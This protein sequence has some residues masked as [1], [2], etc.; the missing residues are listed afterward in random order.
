MHVCVDM[1]MC[2]PWMY[3]RMHEMREKEEH[4]AGKKLR[5]IW[6][7][8]RVKGAEGREGQFGLR[9]SLKGTRHERRKEQ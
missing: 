5:K 2:Y 1:Y 7:K 9:T 4:M 3:I 8:K 6:T